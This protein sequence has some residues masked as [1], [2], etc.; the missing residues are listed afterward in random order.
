MEQYAW[1]SEG[2]KR[3][4]DRAIIELNKANALRKLTNQ[5]ELPIKEEDVKALYVKWG[6]LVLGDATTVLGVPEGAE[7]FIAEKQVEF[8][9]EK[10][11]EKKTK[12]KK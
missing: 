1:V 6:G 12:H 7:E 4:F 9:E 11:A 8:A 5:P 3:K 2:S 10:K